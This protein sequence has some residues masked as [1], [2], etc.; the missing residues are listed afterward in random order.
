MDYPKLETALLRDVDDT[1]YF[2]AKLPKLPARIA[3]ASKKTA[4]PLGR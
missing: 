2:G 1:Y 4:R 3:T